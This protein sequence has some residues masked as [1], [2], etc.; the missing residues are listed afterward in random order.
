MASPRTKS[1]PTSRPNAAVAGID[2]TGTKRIPA[3]IGVAFMGDTKGGAVRHRPGDLAREWLRLPANPNGTAQLRCAQ[4]LGERHG[5]DPPA[6]GQVDRRFRVGA[7][8]EAEAALYEGA[9]PHTSRNT[10]GRCGKRNRRES[11]RLHWWRHHRAETGHVGRRLT[12]CLT[13]HRDADGSQAPAVR[14]ARRGHLPRLAQLIAIARDDDTTFGILH[15]RFHEAWSL[16]LGTSLGE[17]IDPR[18]T[19]TTTFATFPFPPGLSLQPVP[20]TDHA[21]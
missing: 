10:S 7:C 1:M 19:P 16:R 8:R 11:Y 20:A 4:A 5:R 15:S 9:F 18:Y 6:R 13:L 14:L 3:N 21:D 17:G 12:D 2:L